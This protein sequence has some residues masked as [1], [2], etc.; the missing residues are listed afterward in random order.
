MIPAIGKCFGCKMISAI[1]NQ[2]PLNFMFFKER[3]TTQVLLDFL[4]RLLC[5]SDRRVN[6]V[7]L[8]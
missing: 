8:G 2:G 5:K 7:R 4:R 1:N 3:F 6:S